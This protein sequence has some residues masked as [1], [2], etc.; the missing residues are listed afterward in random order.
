MCKLHPVCPHRQSNVWSW[1]EIKG[2]LEQG[3]YSGKK[4]GWGHNSHNFSSRSIYLS[5]AKNEGNGISRSGAGIARFF[6]RPTVKHWFSLEEEIILKQLWTYNP[7]KKCKVPKTEMGSSAN[8][9]EGRDRPYVH[10]NQQE[11]TFMWRLVLCRLYHR[12]CSVEWQNDWWM[13]MHY[14][15]QSPPA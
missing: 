4:C 12:L 15:K 13:M 9:Q 11:M 5:T 10:Q 6:R 2:L 1:H 3:W 7:Q 8:L 14:H